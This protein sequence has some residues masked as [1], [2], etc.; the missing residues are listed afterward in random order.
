M[1]RAKGPQNH[2]R[3]CKHTARRKGEGAAYKSHLNGEG[4]ERPK[5]E[6]GEVEKQTKRTQ[7][8]TGELHHEEKKPA[9]QDNLKQ[10]LRPTPLNVGRGH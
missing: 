2:D 6:K 1:Y 9:L 10:E 8:R 4:G 3:T 5:T 7:E